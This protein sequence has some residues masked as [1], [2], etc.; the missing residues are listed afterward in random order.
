SHPLE[1]RGQL[2]REVARYSVRFGVG[3]IPRPP[4]WSGY[5]VVPERIEFWE[6]RAFR[7]HDRIAYRREDGGWRMERL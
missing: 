4:F 2:K 7:L 1:S 6:E 5:R 3:K